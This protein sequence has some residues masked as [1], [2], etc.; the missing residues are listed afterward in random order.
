M[1]IVLL[2][3]NVS[4]GIL[5]FRKDF[6]KYLL[7]LNHQ[8]YCFAIDYTEETKNLVRELGAIPIDYNLEKT[9]LNPFRDIFDTFLLAKKFKDLDADVVFSFFIKP[10]IYGSI[11]AAL[12]GVPRCIAMLE[13]LGYIYTP[14]R[15]KLVFK[16]KILQFVH[17]I[18]ST[19]AF[20]FVDKVLFLNADDPRDLSKFGFY[21]RS[22]FSIIGPIGL[23]LK[24]YSYS[25]VSVGDKISFIFIARLLAE[26]GVFE[27]IEAA[28][29]VKKSFPNVEFILLGGLDPDNPS[30]LSQIELQKVIDEGVVVYPGYVDDVYDWIKRSHIFVLP[31]YYREGVP[32]STQEAMATGR[33]VLT[34]DVPGCRDTIV[35]GVNGFL[36]PPCNPD[37]LASKMVYMIE[38]PDEI[39]RMGNESYKI[40]VRRYDVD[41]INPYL[42]EVVTG[43][44]S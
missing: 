1:K 9:G 30:G 25:E 22:K 44:K 37:F 24:S 19:I 14:V 5:I 20:K 36:I 32:R 17:G 38:H 43:I 34:T 40:A 39:K 27:Y 16:K 12:S 21:D 18:L 42:A 7:S 4:P 35:D 13:G 33:A 10:S 29:Q 26:K 23:N 28:R 2:S 6:I 11:A 41:K 15:G 3:Q 8:V 31:S